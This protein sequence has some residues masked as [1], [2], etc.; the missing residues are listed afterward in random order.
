MPR[1]DLLE[2]ILAVKFELDSAAPTEK[3]ELQEALNRLLEEAGKNGK[4]SRQNILASINLRYTEYRRKRLAQERTSIAR[5]FV[6][7]SANETIFSR[8]QILTAGLE[9]LGNRPCP[10]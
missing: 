3:A 5:K 9:R 6:G 2:K 7:P 4:F 10:S 8:A 1:S